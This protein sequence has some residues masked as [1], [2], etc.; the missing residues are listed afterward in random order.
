MSRKI[1]DRSRGISQGHFFQ[2][3]EWFMKT[4]AWQHATVYERA[5]YLELK[6]RYNGGNNGNISLSHRE[7]MALVK[8]SNTPIENAFKG[9]I[10]KGFIQAQQKGSFG[11]KTNSES[12]GYGRATRWLL[13]ELPQDIPLRVASVGTKDFMKWKPNDE[14]S[15]ARPDR[16]IAAGVS[17]HVGR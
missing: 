3:Y 14:K 16:T 12:A 17:A 5:L 13:T 7:A 1:K 6:R 11:W 8:C 15:T 4:A 9:L 2:I 10:S